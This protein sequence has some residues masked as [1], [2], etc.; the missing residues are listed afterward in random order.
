MRAPTISETGARA[1]RA[2]IPASG[3]PFAI[4]SQART[5]WARGWREAKTEAA[6]AAAGRAL[7]TSLAA[8][9]RAV[10]RR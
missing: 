4:G 3:N 10:R 8:T 2:G 9:R 5:L 1:Y 7:D 6:I